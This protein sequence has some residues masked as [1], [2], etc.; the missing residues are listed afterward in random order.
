MKERDF[1]S[2]FEESLKLSKLQYSVEIR[3]DEAQPICTQWTWKNFKIQARCSDFEGPLLVTLSKHHRS[4]GFNRRARVGYSCFV[5]P[6][7]CWSR[8]KKAQPG[9][10]AV[11]RYIRL[12]CLPL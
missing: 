1:E 7:R 10:R 6:P 8:A 5:V 4:A 3:V 9:L 11:W 12:H 2:R